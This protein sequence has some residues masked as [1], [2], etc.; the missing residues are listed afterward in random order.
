LPIVAHLRR[1]SALPDPTWSIPSATTSPLSPS[2]SRAGRGKRGPV[3]LALTGLAEPAPAREARLPSS[4]PIPR[5]L[6][7]GEGGGARIV[8]V[9]TRA[10]AEGV[11]IGMTS[12][13]ARAR[14]PGLALATLDPARLEAIDLVITT[15]LVEVSPR[16]GRT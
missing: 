9:C 6:V 2:P 4:A 1:L 3:Q 12:A 15:A 7:R 8:S 16:L 13:E 10:R 11:H 5:A 14:L